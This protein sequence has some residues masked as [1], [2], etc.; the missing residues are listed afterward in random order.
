MTSAHVD[1]DRGSV[2][3]ALVM[4]VVIAVAG[5]ALIFDGARYLAAFKPMARHSTQA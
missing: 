5:A 3:V 2:S 1:R 4:M